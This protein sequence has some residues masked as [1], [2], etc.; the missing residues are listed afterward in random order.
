M[1]FVI[2]TP[3]SFVGDFKR[4][5]STYCLYTGKTNGVKLRCRQVIYE[6]KSIGMGKEE[7]DGSNFQGRLIRSRSLLLQ[8]SQHG[9][10]WHRAP[11]GPMAID[12]FKVKTFV[13]FLSLLLPIAKGE[14]GLFI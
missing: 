9:H 2:A 8:M 14:F 12:L 6:R 13:F 7:L 1:I 11:L 10:S 3:S 4:F 5:E